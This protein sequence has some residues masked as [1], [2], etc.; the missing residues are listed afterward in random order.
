[1]KNKTTLIVGLSLLLN[2]I[3]MANQTDIIK[4]RESQIVNPEIP[5]EV[6]VSNTSVNRFICNGN[7][8]DVIYSQE[9]NFSIKVNE[10][11]MFLKLPV[12][13]KMVDGQEKERMVFNEKSEM[14]IN[15]D[16]SIYSVI[17]V[18]M[19]TSSQTIYLQ[20][21]KGDM[22]KAQEF[23]K[24]KTRDDFVI[25]LID[26]LLNNNFPQGFKVSEHGKFYSMPDMN[27]VDFLLYR[28]IEGAGFVAKEFIIYSKDKVK[29]ED[30]QLAKIEDV[31]NP[32]A[33]AILDSEFSGVTKGYVVEAVNDRK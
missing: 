33:V 6:I 27:N 5:T 18:P 11:N 14:Y 25:S 17:I 22:K 30:V 20:N 12:K 9:K 16:G 1:M 24:K 19:Q 29:I 28:T 23:A 7:I 3:A 15:C 10:N 21:P 8:T 13:I 2:T 32:V 31:V 4:P 26:A